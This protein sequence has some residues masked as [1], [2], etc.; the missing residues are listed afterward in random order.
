M[1]RLQLTPVVKQIL[2]GCIVL[3]FG[4]E[5]LRARNTYDLFSLL[6]MHY[7]GSP[8]F[9]PWQVISH[10]FMHG[11]FAHIAFNMFALVS[12]GVIIERIMG[13]KRFLKLFFFSG[14]GAI[15][16]HIGIQVWQ[17]FD[18]TGLWFP[19]LEELGLVIEGD[20]IYADGTFIK[21]QTALDKIGPI[22]GQSI[23][24]ASGAIYGI[25]VAFA[26]LFPNTELIFMF[27]PYPVKAKYMVPIMIALDI[28]FGFS[29]FKWDPV[30]HFAHLGG[31]FTGLAMVYYW[32]RY[33]KRNFW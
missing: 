19:T 2:I 29:N 20:K 22:F 4:T 28:F 24:G 9:K 13:S 16:L 17:V 30:A 10:M 7:P 11:G 5:L 21:S 31:A 8:Q 23:V 33:D 1:N 27:I 3:F 25:I 14:L 32:R 26:F 18:L 6:A 15:A 12:I